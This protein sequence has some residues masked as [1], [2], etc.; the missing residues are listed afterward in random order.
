MKKL[1]SI[2]FVSL[3]LAAPL[4]TFTQP[5]PYQNGNGSTIGGT[6][7]GGPIDGG[8]SIFLLLGAGYGLKKVYNVKKKE[9][10]A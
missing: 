10:E 4:L 8:L 9:K 6:P 2:I 5:L 3:L 7:V 1:R